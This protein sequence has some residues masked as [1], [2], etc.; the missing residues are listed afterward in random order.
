M[1]IELVAIG[2]VIGIFIGML[3]NIYMLK[4]DINK[5]IKEHEQNAN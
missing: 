1:H 2:M 3:I 5:M 4:R